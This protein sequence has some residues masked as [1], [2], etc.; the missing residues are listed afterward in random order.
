[1][2][3]LWS[4]LLYCRIRAFQQALGYFGARHYCRGWF[5]TITASYRYTNIGNLV[6]YFALLSTQRERRV[7]KKERRDWSI[8]QSAIAALTVMSP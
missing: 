7:M 2:G 5:H 8:D 1:M 4:G 6:K 3:R